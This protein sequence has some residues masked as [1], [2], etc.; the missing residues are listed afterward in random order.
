MPNS[1]VFFRSK[2]N[3]IIYELL[4]LLLFLHSKNL[5]CFKNAENM[6]VIDKKRRDV[7]RYCAEE[8]VIIFIKQNWYWYRSCICNLSQKP[9]L[10]FLSQDPSHSAFHP[11][12]R[13]PNLVKSQS[14]FKET[15]PKKLSSCLNFLFLTFSQR[16]CVLFLGCVRCTCEAA[17]I[18]CVTGSVH[19]WIPKHPGLV[20]VRCGHATTFPLNY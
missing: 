4:L 20:P 15:Y 19:W 18:V 9:G 14:D 16:K 10:S 2:A 17:S 12:G 13:T 7:R 3:K 1:L 8:I 5:E 6:T 11:Y